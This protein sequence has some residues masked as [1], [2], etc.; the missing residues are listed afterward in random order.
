MQ[1]LPENRDQGLGAPSGGVGGLS[2][3][4]IAG[5]SGSGIGLAAAG[6]GVNGPGPLAGVGVAAG[7]GPA[8]AGAGAGAGIGVPGAVI[9][10]GATII[11]GPSAA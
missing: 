6:G 9:S 2:G 7:A 1:K 10:V 5:T 4:A 11:A 3:G 8:G